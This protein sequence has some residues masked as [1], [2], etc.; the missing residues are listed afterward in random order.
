VKISDMLA[1]MNQYDLVL[2]AHIK[3]EQS[4][5]AQ[6]LPD[7]LTSGAA[8]SPTGS[9]SLVKRGNYIASVDFA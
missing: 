5:C 6:F 8:E 7:Q 3:G 2:R 9:F 4:G 1:A